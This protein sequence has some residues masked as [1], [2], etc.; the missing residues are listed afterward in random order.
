MEQSPHKV[1]SKDKGAYTLEYYRYQH[2]Y[3]CMLAIKLYA[4]LW[5]QV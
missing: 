1:K 2:S 4:G 5:N 3:T